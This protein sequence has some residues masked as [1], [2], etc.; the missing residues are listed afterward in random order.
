MGII[1]SCLILNCLDSFY[2][3]NGCHLNL[4][5]NLIAEDESATVITMCEPGFARGDL[6]F[7]EK[8]EEKFTKCKKCDWKQGK[9]QK[10][11][12]QPDC[13]D[14]SDGSFVGM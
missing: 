5:F 12:G 7:N 4:T 10:D 8:E 11:A 13:K 14:V 1:S 9:Y 6:F 3:L 2:S